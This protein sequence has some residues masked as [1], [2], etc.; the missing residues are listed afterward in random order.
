MEIFLNLAWALLA[1]SSVCL[2]AS[3]ERRTGPE[4]RLPIVALLLLIIVSFPII[5]VSDDLWSL[6]NP[7]ETDVLLRRDHHSDQQ[8]SIFPT[9]SDAL[10]EPASSGLTLLVRHCDSLPDQP[11]YS[12]A[13]VL[14]TSVQNRPPP[15]A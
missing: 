5:S 12:R 13:A 7:A 11:V 9:F 1:L 8:H 4:R 14:L 15:S 2:W 10:C 3:F 6:Q